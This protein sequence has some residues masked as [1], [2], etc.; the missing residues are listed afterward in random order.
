MDQ[1]ERAMIEAILDH[2]YVEEAQVEG[3]IISAGHA[4]VAGDSR[5]V[6]QAAIRGPCARCGQER[7]DS[8]PPWAWDR[9]S[10]YCRLCGEWGGG[11]IITDP[12]AVIRDLEV[13]RELLDQMTRVQA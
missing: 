4:I 10:S 2:P 1:T 13:R 9:S 12:V 5:L 6:V 11:W 3:W 7:E 8:S